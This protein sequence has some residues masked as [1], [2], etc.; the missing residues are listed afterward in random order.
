MSEYRYGCGYA[1]CRC[2]HAEPCERGW[3]ETPGGVI[4]C[5]VCK[6]ELAAVYDAHKHDAESLQR[7]LRALYAGQPKQSRIL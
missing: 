5:K 4:P 2:T 3:I 6:P 7:A 1:H